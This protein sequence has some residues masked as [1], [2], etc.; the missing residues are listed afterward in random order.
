MTKRAVLRISEKKFVY[1]KS[2]I[3][4]KEEIGN[5]NS[6]RLQKCYQS[7]DRGTKRQTDRQTTLSHRDT[8]EPR[9]KEP[10]NKR[11]GIYGIVS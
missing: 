10:A 6:S 4:E 11:N 2:K 5:Q 1:V 3:F 8:L 9:Y 7:T